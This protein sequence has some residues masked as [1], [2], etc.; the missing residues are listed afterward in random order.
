MTFPATT[1][2]PVASFAD[3]FRLNLDV[4]EVVGWFGYTSAVE[5]L[6]LPRSGQLLPWVDD[7]RIRVEA[8]FPHVS[9]TSETARREFL[10][11]PVLL[12][13][14]RY[15]DVKI[16][17][18]YPIELNERLRG[19]LDYYLQAS[20]D[21]LVIEAKNADLQRGFTQLATEL[22]ALDQLDISTNHRLY[23]AVSL[24]NVWQFGVVERAQ[25]RIIQDLNL[26]RVPADLTELLAIMA[27]I[28]LGD[29]P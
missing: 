19:T 21:L 22:I 14:A 27:G 26:Y 8:S 16:R 29:R 23:G 12:D 13:L 11:A 2:P 7:L 1:M 20:H 10:I 4:D 6:D 3:Y 24:G 28:L 18:E 9:L 5:K 25:K 15:L 17:V